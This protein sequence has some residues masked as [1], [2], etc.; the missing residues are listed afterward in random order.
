M[1]A[2]NGGPQ[3][4]NGRDRLSDAYRFLGFPLL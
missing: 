1:L 3:S 2:R 4:L